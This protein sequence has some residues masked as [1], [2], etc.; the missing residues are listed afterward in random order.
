[1]AFTDGYRRSLGSTGDLHLRNAPTLLNVGDNKY[2]TA[3]DPRIQRLEDQIR[4]PLF[5]TVVIEL[6]VSGHE[7]EV[8]QRFERDREFQLLLEKSGLEPQKLN[9][10]LIIGALA[11]YVR[12]LESRDSPYDRYLKD[13]IGFPLSNLAALGEKLFFSERLHCSHCHGG[14]DFDEPSG[15]E[16]K[17]F[18]QNGFTALEKIDSHRETTSRFDR[19]LEGVT[20]D[21]RDHG[22][23]RIPTLRNVEIT[24]P[25]M[26]DGSIESLSEVVEIYSRGGLLGAPRDPTLESFSLSKD[27]KLA[28]LSFL[29]A[30][31]D[32]SYSGENP[33]EE[34]SSSF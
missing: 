17:Y 13:P 4:I 10:E 5:E 31:T 33:T 2:F 21:P 18:R 1:M 7:D 22:K 29:S 34:H 20:G 8:L 12:Y 30:L 24:G 16:K 25:Y 15:D 26:H 14:R 3:G 27:E 9:W 28:L 6:G 19:G 11:E 23:F 32:S